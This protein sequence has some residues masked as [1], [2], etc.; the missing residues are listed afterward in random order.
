MKRP[1]VIGRLLARPGAARG[2]WRLRSRIVR[3]A[4]RLSRL[5]AAVVRED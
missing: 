4:E 3:D 2:L 5:V 1:R